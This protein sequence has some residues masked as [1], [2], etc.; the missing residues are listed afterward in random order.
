MAKAIGRVSLFPV[1]DA[2][3][4]AKK[5]ERRMARQG[6]TRRVFPGSRVTACP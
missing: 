5:K 3:P 6:A 1:P 2:P 4:R